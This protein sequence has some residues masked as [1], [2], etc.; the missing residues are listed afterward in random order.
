LKKKLG[1][2]YPVEQLIGKNAS[3]KENKHMSIHKDV[4]ERSKNI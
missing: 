2:E 3:A 4:N 1:L